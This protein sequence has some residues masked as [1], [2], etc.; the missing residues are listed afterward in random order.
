MLSGAKDHFL[1]CCHVVAMYNC[2]LSRWKHVPKFLRSLGSGHVHVVI[3][4]A[5][6]GVEAQRYT[7]GTAPNKMFLEV[8]ALCL[9]I[10]YPLEDVPTVDRTT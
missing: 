10:P 4:V 9:D 7:V 8:Y 2:T 5:R 1:S 6:N 3:V